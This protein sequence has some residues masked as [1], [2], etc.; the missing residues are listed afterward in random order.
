MADDKALTPV[1]PW[2]EG[3]VQLSQQQAEEVIATHDHNAAKARPDIDYALL[4]L[5]Q[6]GWIVLAKDGDGRLGIEITEHGI[7]EGPD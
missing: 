7:E 3:Y 5:L 6:R 1:R 4:G 2:P